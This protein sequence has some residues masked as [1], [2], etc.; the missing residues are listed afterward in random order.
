MYSVAMNGHGDL[1]NIHAAR[2]AAQLTVDPAY[3]HRTF[4]I[5]AQ[6]D[7]PT[8]R[9]TYRP[10]LLPDEFQ[11]DD[12]IAKLELSTVLRLVESEILLKKQDRLRILVLYGSLRSR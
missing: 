2:A 4:A 8:I 6:E 12:W 3:A 9:S 5:D 1:N 11:A 10:F 7:D